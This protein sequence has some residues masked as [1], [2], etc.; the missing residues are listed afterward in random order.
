ME[1]SNVKLTNIGSTTLKKARQR[2]FY[3]QNCVPDPLF[4][5]TAL[6]LLSVLPVFLP[7][8]RKLLAAVVLPS[9]FTAL[10]LPSLFATHVLSSFLTAI[11][12]PTL[13][14]TRRP[15][16]AFSIMLTAM[17]IVMVTTAEQKYYDNP[18]HF[19]TRHYCLYNICSLL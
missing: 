15:S 13:H 12:L 3:S 5:A 1:R 8:R 11:V 2:F 17:M 4:L 6:I 18:V 7:I 10:T 19:F 16:F 9:L 14:A